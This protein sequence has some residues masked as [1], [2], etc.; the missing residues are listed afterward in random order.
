[1]ADSLRRIL[2]RYHRRSFCHIQKTSRMRLR[3]NFAAQGYSIDAFCATGRLYP[4]RDCICA[5]PTTLPMKLSAVPRYDIS[6]ARA[7]WNP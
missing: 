5:E 7:A 1:M 2:F 4:V 6:M 3:R